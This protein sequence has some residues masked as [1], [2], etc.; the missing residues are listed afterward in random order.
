[1]SFAQSNPLGELRLV[2][3]KEFSSQSTGRTVATCWRA[4][5][6]LDSASRER[7]SR[8]SHLGVPALG[9]FHRND[10]S[11]PVVEKL[12][13]RVSVI[14]RATQLSCGRCRAE[15]KIDAHTRG[16][17]PQGRATAGTPHPKRPALEPCG[18]TD[19]ALKS[20]GSSGLRAMV[21]IERLEFKMRPR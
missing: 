14:A 19:N 2:G 17:S 5:V 11:Q 20:Y 8:P 12:C 13:G 10:D 3:S 1:V 9:S 15:R 6:R 18:S 21:Q 16:A 7:I 4:P